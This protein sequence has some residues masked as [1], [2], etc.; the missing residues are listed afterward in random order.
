[1]VDKSLSPGVLSN[2]EMFPSSV[3]H[4]ARTVPWSSAKFPQFTNANPARDTETCGALCGKLT[5]DEFTIIHVIIPDRC[6]VW[7]LQHGEWRRHFLPPDE[8]G[9]L[10]LGWSHTPLAVFLSKVELH[11]HCSYQMMLPGSPAPVCMLPS[12]SKLTDHRLQETSFCSHNGFH[13]TKNIPLS[14]DC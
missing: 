12:G 10:L 3:D 4:T 9:V 14:C 8:L 13:T 5:R 2:P 1:M 6:W 11:I 7:L